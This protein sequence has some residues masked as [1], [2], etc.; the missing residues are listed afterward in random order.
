MTAPSF[1]ES[2]LTIGSKIG[3]YFGLV[4]MLPALFLVLWSATLAVSDAWR[5]APKVGQLSAFAHWTSTGIAW[6]LLAS[7]VAG[8]FVHPLQFATTQVLEGYWGTSFL[9]RKA[10]L[11]RI[12]HYSKRRQKLVD[13]RDAAAAALE[14]EVVAA[15]TA[16]RPE[17]PPPWERTLFE[18]RKKFLLNSEDGEQFLHR[19]VDA[20]V[21]AYAA[22]RFPDPSRIL[23]TRLGNALRREEDRVGKQYGLDVLKVLPH[24]LLTAPERHVDHVQDA[25]QQLDTTVRLGVVSLLATLETTACLLTDGWWLLVALGPYALTYLAYRAAIAAADEYT[26]A[27]KILTDLNRFTLYESLHVRLPVSTAEEKRNSAALVELLNG[28]HENVSYKHP[29]SPTPPGNP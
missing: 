18:K 2:T 19:I 1:A 15:L 4:S 11:L 9:G 13:A 25:R 3:R 24:L 5:G 16:I 21:F 26:T 29:A 28:K 14:A 22:S 10:A 20:E 6:I 27:V 8:L 12:R 23:P 7:L 17:D